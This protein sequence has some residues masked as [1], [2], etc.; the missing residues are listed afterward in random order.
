MCLYLRKNLD[1]RSSSCDRTT[2]YKVV[3]ELN[4]GSFRTPYY[5]TPIVLGRTIEAFYF[6]RNN[7]KRKSRKKSF[8]NEKTSVGKF[9]N[10]KE[11]LRKIEGGVIHCFYDLNAARELCSMYYRRVILECEVDPKDWIADCPTYKET[12]Y[13]KILPVRVVK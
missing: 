13:L 1:F 8:T 10:G 9:F 3:D 12:A 5:R 2:V 7:Q 11:I 4:N 6:D